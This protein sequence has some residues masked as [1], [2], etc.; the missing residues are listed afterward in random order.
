MHIF[1]LIF[2]LLKKSPSGPLPVVPQNDEGSSEDE[3]EEELDEDVEANEAD[4]DEDDDDDD[5]D[6]RTESPM[7]EK[8]EEIIKEYVIIR[9]N[10]LTMWKTA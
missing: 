6:D 1:N 5:D 4:D 7:S 10:Q 2:L 8:Y 3:L 9:C